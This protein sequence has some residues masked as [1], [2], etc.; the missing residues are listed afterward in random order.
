MEVAS[1]A[2]PPSAFE[3]PLVHEGE[4]Y[5]WSE[6]IPSP[7]PTER[8]RE[9]GPGCWPTLNLPPGHPRSLK[10]A[11]H[12]PADKAAP[13]LVRSPC[14]PSKPQRLTTSDLPT[15]ISCS[16]SYTSE[17]RLARLPCS[18][19]WHRMSPKLSQGAQT[20]PSCFRLRPTKSTGIMRGNLR[21][22]GKAGAKRSSNAR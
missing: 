10:P 7:H 17:P 20:Q 6:G 22:E 12:Q 15:T 16:Q 13:P 8:G 5:H 9:K 4:P 1:S 21:E 14:N 11:L 2:R 18:A 3:Y 19:A